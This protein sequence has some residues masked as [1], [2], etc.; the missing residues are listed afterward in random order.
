MLTGSGTRREW[1]NGDASRRP[2]DEGDGLDGFG[3]PAARL[4][5]GGIAGLDSHSIHQVHAVDT[6]REPG[7]TSENFTYDIHSIPFDR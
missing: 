5:R 6:N 2:T 4:E 3:F 1:A 7:A